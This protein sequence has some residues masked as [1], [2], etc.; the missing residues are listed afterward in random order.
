[1]AA[2]PLL[3]RE[4]GSGTRETLEHA[5]RQH[6]LGLT[7]GLEMASNTALTAAARSGMGPVVLSELALA[8][9]LRAGHLVAVPVDDLP[10]R[11]PLTAVW[12]RDRAGS[13]GV[14]TLLRVTSTD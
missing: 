7:A 8:A 3:V 5:L 10:L 9:E 1:M 11:R 13:A 14:V 12:R 4:V 6:G 2:T